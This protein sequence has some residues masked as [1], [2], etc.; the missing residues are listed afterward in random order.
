MNANSGFGEAQAALCLPRVER[1]RKSCPL[2]SEPL[3]SRRL[4]AIP[5]QQGARRSLPQWGLKPLPA[6]LNLVGAGRPFASR[7]LHGPSMPP[8]GPAPLTAPPSLG[9]GASCPLRGFVCRPSLA[10]WRQA[11]RHPPAL[12]A[13]YRSGARALLVPRNA[14][15]GFVPLSSLRFRR[16]LRHIG[17]MLATR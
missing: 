16:P 10:G 15:C 14:L 7:G 1:K 8:A 9:P 5:G 17:Q 2:P 4:H 13:S 6:S 12:D 3:P 11:G